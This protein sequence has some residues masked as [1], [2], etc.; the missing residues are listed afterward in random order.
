MGWS[1]L[2]AHLPFDFHFDSHFG[3]HWGSWLEF[4][5]HLGSFDSQSGFVI[6]FGSPFVFESSLGSVIDCSVDFGP[7]MGRSVDFGYRYHQGC[8][9]DWCW[10]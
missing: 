9:C 7:G 3:F 2:P 5:Y 10:W 4:L 6:E 8:G 1:G